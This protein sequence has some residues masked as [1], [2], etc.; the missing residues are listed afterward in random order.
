[1]LSIPSSLLPIPW[2]LA[3][4]KRA[5][6]CSHPHSVQAAETLELQV[7]LCS[8]GQSVP[9]GAV[10]TCIL[11]L[12]H[13]LSTSLW[14]VNQRELRPILCL[15]SHPPCNLINPTRACSTRRCVGQTKPVCGPDLACRLPFATFVPCKFHWFGKHLVNYVGGT[16]PDPRDRKVTGDWKP[17]LTLK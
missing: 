14:F 17:V 11:G 8:K 1:M 6:W 2:V 7:S 3:S 15:Q 12:V 9:Q 10:A 4:I 5:F 13:C 16:K